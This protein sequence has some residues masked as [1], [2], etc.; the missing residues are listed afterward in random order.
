LA[1][2][3]GRSP[4]HI[5]PKVEIGWCELVD[6]PSLG[7]ERVIA[8]M[9]SGAATSAIHASRIKPFSR[10]NDIWVEFWFRPKAGDKAKR[11]EARVV[12]RRMVRSSNGERQD[13]Y[14]I[15]AQLCLGKMCWN[16][17]LTLA[18]RRAMTFPVLVGRQALKNGFLVNS[19]RRWV[20]GKK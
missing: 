10:N 20:L 8:K 2:S 6:I 16:G 17:Q 7:L 11:H 5:I 1:T 12:D 18:N 9:D 15:E 13:R 19:A 4:R 3:S 14:V